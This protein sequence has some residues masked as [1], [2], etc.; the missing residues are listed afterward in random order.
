[1]LPFWVMWKNDDIGLTCSETGE[2]RFHSIQST[3]DIHNFVINVVKTAAENRYPSIRIPNPFHIWKL[4]PH[5]MAF[6]LPTRRR[7]EKSY[8]S[9]LTD[10]IFIVASIIIIIIII[11]IIR[12]LLSERVHW[13]QAQ[14]PHRPEVE[15]EQPA[16]QL[17]HYIHRPL[18]LDDAPN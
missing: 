8:N 10:K 4:Y 17:Q 18:F 16:V 7:A 1:M 15:K 5:R 12:V 6:G 3:K 13:S 2:W 14:T 9:G 11:I